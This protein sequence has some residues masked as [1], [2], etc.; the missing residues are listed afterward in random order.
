MK[1]NVNVKRGGGD[2][3][4]WLLAHPQRTELSRALE[5]C[6]HNYVHAQTLQ[7]MQK[8]LGEGLFPDTAVEKSV[9]P[10]DVGGI[11]AQPVGEW[12]FPQSPTK[13]KIKPAFEG[14]LSTA[15]ERYQG[16][17]FCAE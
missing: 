3:E 5:T 2:V 8:V 17:G 16:L 9:R 14:A 12:P 4:G 13:T 7:A 10:S 15:P 11:L 1:V 6:V